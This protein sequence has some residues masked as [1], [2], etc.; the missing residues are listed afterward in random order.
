MP[1]R[2]SCERESRKEE[3][4]EADADAAGRV[5]YSSCADTPPNQYSSCYR[6]ITTDD[7]IV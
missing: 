7:V 1:R 4:L 6:Y 2:M 5:G 3:R